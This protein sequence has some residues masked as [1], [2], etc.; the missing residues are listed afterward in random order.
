MVWG[1]SGLD[2]HPSLVMRPAW[3]DEVA[4]DGRPRWPLALVSPVGATHVQ[5]N[6]QIH[7]AHTQTNIETCIDTD[8]QT[9]PL[10]TYTQKW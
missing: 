1:W 5:T 6:V 9:V 10:H 8:T 2:E 7:T 4:L 3:A